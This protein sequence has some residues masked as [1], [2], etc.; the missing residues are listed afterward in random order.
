MVA[1]LI[2]ATI[3]EKF[4]SAALGAYMKMIGALREV[5]GMSAMGCFIAWQGQN[6]AELKNNLDLMDKTIK[7]HVRLL[8]TSAIWSS[9]M[10][11]IENSQPL[12]NYFSQFPYYEDWKAYMKSYNYA[13]PPIT[14]EAFIYNV[15]GKYLKQ[16]PLDVLK[17]LVFGNAAMTFDYICNIAQDIIKT[18]EN[19]PLK[20][21]DTINS[22]TNTLDLPPEVG[23][24]PYGYWTTIR[25]FIW[26]EWCMVKTAIMSMS[27]YRMLLEGGGEGLIPAPY[28]PGQRVHVLMNNEIAGVLHL[29]TDGSV[30]ADLED[31]PELEALTL[32]TYGLKLN[33]LTRIRPKLKY[34]NDTKH[35]EVR[36]DDPMQVKV[37]TDSE[38]YTV[39]YV[40][41][42]PPSYWV[43]KEPDFD[44]I[45]IRYKIDKNTMH[46]Q[47]YEGEIADSCSIYLNDV[48]I[49]HRPQGYHALPYKLVYDKTHLLE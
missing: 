43:G 22:N 39:L 37:E 11:E 1:W 3:V 49:W 27:A 26:V 25:P 13:P 10:Q 48:L 30:S 16:S 31:D 6:M 4:A 29:A 8:T 23:Y 21:V 44:D 17:Q 38:G 5:Y 34:V 28:V 24:A 35:Y 19:D 20:I 15:V 14:M 47:I 40:E 18:E 46:L 9:W 33:I 32:D 41:D 7:L 2:I 42:L 12:D 45:M 36:L